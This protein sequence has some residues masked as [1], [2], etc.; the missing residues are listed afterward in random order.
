MLLRFCRFDGGM[1]CTDELFLL[2]EWE[3]WEEWDKLVRDWPAL[4]SN[5]IRQKIRSVG[6]SS[7]SYG[8]FVITYL[9]GKHMLQTIRLGYINE[10]A[11]KHLLQHLK[12]KHK[13][14]YSHVKKK[15]STGTPLPFLEGL[16]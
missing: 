1:E 9:A 4:W 15:V 13:R 7:N 10:R 11:A 16:N 6:T 14:I 8:G 2:E 12:I 3:E 5:C